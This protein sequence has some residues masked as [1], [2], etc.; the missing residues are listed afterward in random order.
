MYVCMYQRM[1]KTVRMCVMDECD[2]IM[3]GW[4]C[5]CNASEQMCMN[6]YYEWMC[7]LV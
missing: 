7:M 6:V 5:M 1:C 4:V 3:Y 2:S